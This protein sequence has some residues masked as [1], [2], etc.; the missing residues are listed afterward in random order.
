MRAY[1]RLF[2]RY[3]DVVRLSCPGHEDFVLAFHPDD[4]QHI[5]C[6]NHRNFPKGKRYHE[7]IPVLG[8]GL[9]NSEGELWR[10]QRRLV[11]SQFS[12]KS[13]TDL[14]PLINRHASELLTRWDEQPA[15][16][17][18][19]V[20]DDMLDVS[21]NIAGEAF[22]G[23]A[24]REHTA[25]VRDSFKY[26][27]SV[28]LERM[29]SPL[30]LPLAWPLPRHR[31]FRR[32]MQQIDG[33]ID[34]IIAEYERSKSPS[35]N[36]LVRLMQAVDPETGEEMSRGQLRDEIKTILMV[37]HE[38]SSVTAVWGLYLLAERPDVRAR[39][40]EEIDTVLRGREPQAED[41]ERMRYLDMVF[42][43]CLRYLP[44]VPFIL[45]SPLADDV[46]GG[47]RVRAGSTVAIVPWVTH[48]HPKFWP[49]P[50]DF[51]PERFAE[52]PKGLRHK[53]SYLPFGAG[54]R[55]C[56]GEFMGQVE[57]K[58][59]L[60][61]LLQRY[62]LALAPGFEP[63]CR[64]FISLQPVGGMLMSCHRRE[65]AARERS[66]AVSHDPAPVP[67]IVSQGLTG[68]S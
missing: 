55:I 41:L 18:R 64:G 24:L 15:S 22:F 13:T 42:Q 11:Q 27:L 54:Q 7:L 33:V 65:V 5:L 19:D 38:T 14:I 10:R 36:V 8:M 52:G 3:G 45:R 50:L 53:L 6:K 28:A 12:S 31:R 2:A 43:E 23:S 63:K 32:A 46:L 62:E 25:L 16:F 61:R 35:A 40:V 47:Y 57:G 39:L 66:A 56:L 4:I 59:L 37:G 1:E 51:R 9:V 49:E 34:H 30:P 58:I 21:F 20:N 68:V 60:A 67:S 17:R 48:R 44:S 26:A 29:Y